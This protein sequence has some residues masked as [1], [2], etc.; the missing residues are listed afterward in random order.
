MHTVPPNWIIFMGVMGLRLFSVEILKYH[1]VTATPLKPLNGLL[2]YL[3]RLLV[4]MCR[5]AYS[6]AV[7]IVIFL[8]ESLDLDY[9]VSPVLVTASPP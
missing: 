5:C 4:M 1:L 8:W 3:V 9:F 7:L 2:S 6:T